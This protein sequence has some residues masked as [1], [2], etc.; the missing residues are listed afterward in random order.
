[1]ANEDEFDFSELDKPWD[2]VEQ[3]SETTVSQ[4]FSCAVTN[5]WTT[6][7]ECSNEFLKNSSREPDMEDEKLTNLNDTEAAS[8]DDERIAKGHENDEFSENSV[9]EREAEAAVEREPTELDIE[10]SSG[11]QSKKSDSNSDNDKEV[12]ESIHQKRRI[13]PGHERAIPIEELV[14]ELDMKEEGAYLISNYSN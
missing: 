2:V 5:G 4:H 11:L 6:A 12:S 8:L 3:T 14:R 9:M 7:V 10:L 13:C 1:M